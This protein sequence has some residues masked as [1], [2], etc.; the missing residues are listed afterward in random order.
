VG[1]RLAGRRSRRRNG[2]PSDFLAPG[3]ARFSSFSSMEWK[4]NSVKSRP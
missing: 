4:K 1:D 3:K 2:R